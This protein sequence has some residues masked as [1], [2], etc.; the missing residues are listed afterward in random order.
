MNARAAAANQHTPHTNLANV[1]T[2]FPIGGASACRACGEHVLRLLLLL[3]MPVC[4]V[5]R[6]RL[7]YVCASCRSNNM[8]ALHSHRHSRARWSRT[9][10][11]RAARRCFIVFSVVNVY[12]TLPRVVAVVT[13]AT[14]LRAKRIREY[15]SNCFVCGWCTCVRVCVLVCVCVG[16]TRDAGG[17]EC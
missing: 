6:S 3:L 16:D 11:T 14:S 8:C 17:G 15:K 1:L 4:A 9:K 12:V 7:Q 13:T 5:Q 2:Q 10:C